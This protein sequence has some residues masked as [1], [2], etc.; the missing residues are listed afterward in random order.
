MNS[1]GNVTIN[2]CGLIANTFFNDIIKLPSDT[3][4][5]EGNTVTLIEEGIAW[6]S[7]LDYKFAQP[8]GF[9][10]KKCV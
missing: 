2:P 6:Q 10:Q 3:V 1:F 4:D 7:D 5:V 8:D 9:K